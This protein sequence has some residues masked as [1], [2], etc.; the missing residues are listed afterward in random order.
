LDFKFIHAADIHLDSPLRGLERYEGAP[1]EKIRGATREAFINLIDLAIEEKVDFMII[2][3]DLYDGDWKDY[4]TG[5]FFAN[6]MS[7]LRKANIP[8]YTIRG[9]H[10]AASHITKQVRLP[11]NVLE[12]ST[13]QP[14]SIQIEHLKVAIHGQGFHTKSVTD[15][16]S[17]TYPDAVKDYFNIGVLHTSAG[18]REG[19]ETYAPCSVEDLASKGYQY[20]ALGHI[21]KR[22][23][24]NEKEPWIIF[25][26]NLQGRHIRETGEKGCT[27]VSV[28]N[29]Q[30]DNVEHKTLDI[31][32]WCICKIDASNI[33]SLE[34][35]VEV[36]NEELAKEIS[37]AEGRLLS[38][39]FIFHGSSSVHERLLQKRENFINN[40][41]A[42]ATDLGHGNVWVEKVKVRT[43]RMVDLQ[44][45]LDRNPALG[46]IFDSINRVSQDE[47][48][49]QDILSEFESLKNVL[50][51]EAKQGDDVLDLTD[52]N[53]LRN[54]L[55]EVEDV[56]FNYLL[57]SEVGRE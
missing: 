50:P 20:W 38:V 13:D 37:K 18:G 21:H 3:G 12:L 22:E 52:S 8:V 1:V 47:K 55:N 7:R 40:L 36:A 26:G 48:V 39:R 5:L 31:L 6:Q 24:L 32:R 14:E 17:Q 44:E 9:N 49:F 19:H 53:V 25:P 11:V 28:K 56:I 42:M 29:G 16:L 57:K 54:R 15:N 43:E 46:A 27:L 2:A 4:N 34:E 33:G 45:V 51:L 10:D 41:R 23:I 35:L 30:V